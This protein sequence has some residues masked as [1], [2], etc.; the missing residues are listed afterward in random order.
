MSAPILENA[1]AGWYY[2]NYPEGPQHDPRCL[3]V[4]ASWQALYNLPITGRTRKDGGFRQCADGIIVH[5][6]RGMAEWATFDGDGL[7]RLVLAAHRY[8]CRVSIRQERS[9]VI[10]QVNT[11]MLSGDLYHRHPGLTDL[12]ERA[13]KLLIEAPAI[14]VSPKAQ[15]ENHG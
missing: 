12:A 15:D 9:M 8:H 14:P 1:R 2:R 13:M 11:R 6:E 3:A 4:L 7:T 5:I 10:V